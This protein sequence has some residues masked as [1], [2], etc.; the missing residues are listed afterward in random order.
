MPDS[1]PTLTAE[2]KAAAKACGMT[3]EEYVEF[4]KPQPKLPPRE[5]VK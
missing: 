2:E 5:K 4:Q 1:E 3:D